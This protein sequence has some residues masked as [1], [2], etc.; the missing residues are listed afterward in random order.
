[1][2][3]GTAGLGGDIGIGISGVV[4]AQEGIG[5]CLLCC[6][7]QAQGLQEAACES[8]VFRQITMREVPHLHYFSSLPWLFIQLYYPQREKINDYQLSPHQ[9]FTFLSPIFVET[10]KGYCRTCVKRTLDLDKQPL[11]KA[12]PVAFPSLC[13]P[14]QLREVAPA[15][16]SGGAGGG[17]T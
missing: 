4:C 3:L 11:A 17:T 14:L 7:L 9:G 6:S 10:G 2:S 13:E 12:K 16:C 8:P 5:V 1:M 15:R